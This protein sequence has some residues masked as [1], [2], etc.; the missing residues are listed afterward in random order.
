[1]TISVMTTCYQSREKYWMKYLELLQENLHILKD[2]WR[3]NFETQY[4]LVTSTI[5]LQDL[6]GTLYNDSISARNQNWWRYYYLTQEKGIAGYAREA[7]RHRTNFESTTLLLSIF[8]YVCESCNEFFITICQSIHWILYGQPWQILGV[9]LQ[10]WFH[11]YLVVGPVL[12]T[13]WSM[14]MKLP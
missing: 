5:R 9:Q 2:W 13:T 1:M 6:T 4:Y 8:I 3:S 14:M 10:K 12:D 7:Q 11:F